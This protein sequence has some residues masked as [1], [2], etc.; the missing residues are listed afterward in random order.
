MSHTHLKEPNLQNP[1][2]SG[3]Q[4]HLPYLESP[5]QAHLSVWS[6]LSPPTTS[7]P[8]DILHHS[9][10]SLGTPLQLGAVHSCLTPQQRDASQNYPLSEV[11]E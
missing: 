9:T 11:L 7:G 10:P 6:D 3:H 8:K 5:G 2:S 4:S 1:T